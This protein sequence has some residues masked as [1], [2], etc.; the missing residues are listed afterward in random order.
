MFIMPLKVLSLISESVA[1]KKIS[2]S[3]Y[4]MKA[5]GECTNEFI[6]R[7]L[8]LSVFAIEL[9]CAHVNQFED[10]NECQLPD[11]SLKSDGQVLLQRMAA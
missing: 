11:G 4:P 6:N 8:Y 7:D 5:T 3:K 9:D 2:S 1:W 10:L